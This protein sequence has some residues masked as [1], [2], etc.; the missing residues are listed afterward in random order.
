MSAWANGW[1]RFLRNYGPIPTNDN[2]YDET[3]Q[4]A[5]RRLR[6]RPLELKAQFLDEVLESLEAEP[7]RSVIL[8]G[9]AG[10]GKTYHCREAFLR[11]GGSADRW[12]AGEMIQRLPLGDRELIV[13]KDLS[14]LRTEISQQ[15]LEDLTSDLT[16][17]AST[18]VYLIAANHGQLMDRLR[19]I[20]SLAG[21]EVTEA[22]EEMLVTR[23]ISAG[24][25]PLVLFDLSRAP[26]ADMVGRVIDEMTGHEGWHDCEGC[27][28]E[29]GE[30]VCPIRE[31]RRRL[32]GEGD[33]GRF[34]RRL[35]SLIEISEL[36]G[37]HFPIRQQLALVAN[38]LLGHPHARDGLMTCADAQALAAG[39][40]VDG[41]SVFRNVFGENLKPSR[42]E[43]TDVFRK[44]GLFGIGGE[45]SNRVDNLLVY[46][47]DDPLMAPDYERLVRSDGV[48][49]A[50]PAYGYA[51]RR[52]LEGEEPDTR[53]QFLELLRAQRQR[54][55]FTLP[56][57]D[58]QAYALWDLTVFRFGGEYL[59]A[60]Q[61]LTSGRPS[62][63]VMALVVRGLNRIFTGLLLQNQE[64]LI[65]ATSGSHSH[66][67]A[68]SLLD[69]I[70]SVPR[71]GGQEVA[72]SP[73]GT[74]PFEVVVRLSRD[75][76]PGPVRFPLTPTRFEFL[77]R[78]SEGALPSSFSLECHEDLL[79][80]KARLLAAS[81]RIR[82]LDTDEPDLG[83][84]EMVLRFIDVN[85][86][87]RASPRRVAVRL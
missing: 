20:G 12:N 44:L 28:L 45:T 3:I 62:A 4:R 17:A 42:A 49:G 21:Q 59:A 23:K 57:E 16:D 27:P 87:G 71:T 46:G 32:I 11:L 72:L 56:D 64:D 48:Y 60:A 7:P 86:E 58:A 39:S 53:G 82:E 81:Q 14:E 41:A 79:A 80:F 66:S 67:K 69:E 78:V 19:G 70:I 43:K 30:A 74:G 35:G 52:Y 55:F 13:V 25:L 24:G 26:A 50:T 63:R 65:L 68:S 15:V 9:T 73:N 76:D 83:G 36:N 5:L 84:D 47:A 31:N 8:T 75:R 85:D 77:G 29:T 38:T 37:E 18:R 40:A 22:V 34:R 10:D 2:M 54:L 51:Q 6:I 1:V 61:A 33:G